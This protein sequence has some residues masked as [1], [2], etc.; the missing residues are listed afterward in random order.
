MKVSSLLVLSF[1][2]LT[3][4]KSFAQDDT[5]YQNVNLFIENWHKNAAEADTAYFDKIAEGGIYIGTDAT[6][7]W[8]KEKFVDWSRKYFK[9]GKAW[10]FTTI[11]RNIYFSDD[12]KLAWFDELVN[13]GMGVC[14]ASGVLKSTTNGW[15]IVHYHLGITIPNEHVKEIKEIIESN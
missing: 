11:E 7:Y 9:R 5:N 12:K 6:E 15:E 10:T 8:T 2:L 1:L 14:R 3:S 4:A 13:T